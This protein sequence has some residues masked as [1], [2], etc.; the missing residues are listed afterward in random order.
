[1]SALLGAVLLGL[2]PMA[3]AFMGFAHPAVITVA[4]VLILSYGLQRTGVIDSLI[5]T[6]LPAQA[7]VGW[8]LLL[9]MLLG[10]VMSAFINNVG[11]M[12]M[13]IPIAL[14]L[15]QQ[16]ELPAARLLMPLS[17]ATILGGMTTLIGTPP[18]LIVSGFRADHLGNGFAL[19]DFSAVGLVVA[20]AG[21]SLV[22]LLSRWLIPARATSSFDQFRTGAYRFEARIP[23][24][25]K[26]IG[27]RLS[28]LE[29]AL[30]SSDSQIIGM[31]RNHVAVFA[32][33]PERLLKAEDVIMLESDPETI[34]TTLSQLGLLLETAKPEEKTDDSEQQADAS[35]LD[36]EI[37]THEWVIMPGALMAGRTAKQIGVYRR[38]GLLLLALSRQGQP[39]NRRL[40]STVFQAGDLVLLQGP[41]ESMAAF[42]QRYGLAPLAPRAIHIPE[43]SKAWL[44]SLIMLLAISSMVLGW[45]SA[46]VAFAAAVVLY[47]VIGI[48]PLREIYSAIEGSTIVLIAALFPVAAAMSATG[49]AD[50]LADLVFSHLSQAPPALLIAGIM[51]ITM[52]LSDFM[53]NAATAAIMCPIALSGAQQLGL[54][55]DSFLM[56]VAIGASCAFLT[57]IGHQ[58]NT[59]ILGPAGLRFG[60]YWRLG[61]PLE[62]LIIALAVPMLLWRWPL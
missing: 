6:L 34:A 10:A 18:N 57:P 4:C 11:A 45:L 48:V 26:L 43:R 61:L 1:M 51:V 16:H 59:L 14:K 30:E 9:L 31:M 32:P 8:H 2:V 53:N 12:A 13:M 38:F 35:P 47:A 29:Q 39:T 20:L 54:N 28:D 55:A 46:A 24:E 52:T 56:A 27:Q 23:P 5:H 15:A 37:R 41:S 49:T 44:A 62:L 17:F 36:K 33:A 21:I 25:H 3:D 58:N 40:R 60:D 50:L 42:A 19:F 22:L 7:S